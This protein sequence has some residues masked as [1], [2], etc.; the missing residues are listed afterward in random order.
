M[1][2]YFDPS[3]NNI[4]YVDEYT[5]D[6]VPLAYIYVDFIDDLDCVEYFY[7]FNKSFTYYDEWVGF[8]SY[9]TNI[10]DIFDYVDDNCTPLYISNKL[11]ICVLFVNL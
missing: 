11:S 1:S 5:V 4:R 8:D 6:K 9:D 2:R 3:I 10:K 7:S